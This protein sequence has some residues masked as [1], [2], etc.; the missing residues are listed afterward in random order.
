[1][2]D[3]AIP[4]WKLL[5]ATA[6]DRLAEAR[7]VVHWAAR[8]VASVGNTC[9]RPLDDGSHLA[10]TWI[11]ESGMLAGVFTTGTPRFRVA[12]RVS[13]LTLHLL[14]V[15]GASEASTELQSKTLAEGYE[16]LSAAILAFSG[17][18]PAR[19]LGPPKHDM[20]DHAIGTGAPFRIE[21]PSEFTELARWIQ[22]GDLMLRAFT[23][24]D[25][26]ASAVRCWP[27]RLDLSTHVV[28]DEG[29]EFDR[30]RSLTVALHLGDGTSS[31]RFRITP[32]PAPAS[33]D[34]R[35]LPKGAHWEEEPTLAAVLPAE[36]I[37]EHRTAEAQAACVAEFLEHGSA[38]AQRMLTAE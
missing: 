28:L 34:L 23:E 18:P 35:S 4:Q 37:V 33:P 36:A 11:A 12:L 22:D 27:Q 15:E 14:S 16:W 21:H 8:L 6:P 10:M 26:R 7:G 38:A 25:A 20:P 19:P 5:G 32:S 9:L 29:V 1:M 30:A 17:A 31:P 2:F 24:Q 3:A 13:D